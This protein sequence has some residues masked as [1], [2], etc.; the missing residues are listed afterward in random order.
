MTAPSPYQSADLLLRLYDLRREPALRAARDWFFFH[1]HPRSA[2]E[3]FETWVGPA[4]EQYRMVT[5]YWDMAAALVR[6]GA[7]DADMFHATNTEYVTLIAKLAPFLPE[8]RRRAR[9]PE[10]LREVELLVA[11]MPDAERRLEVMRRYLAHK[12]EEHRGS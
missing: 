11:E 5:S 1:F 6:H 3:V 10:Y 12:A 9:L 8:L 7:I 2:D 4:S